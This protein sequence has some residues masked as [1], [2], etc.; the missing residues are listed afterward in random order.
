VSESAA[1]RLRS[2][3]FA[4]VDV[5]T[6]G[7]ESGEDR[8][9]EVAVVRADATGVVTHEWA[10]AVDPG[11]PVRLTWVHGLTDE[12][13]RGAPRFAEVAA[14]LAARLTGAVL[15]GHNV[16]FD[17]A[18]LRAEYERAG[19]PM[20]PFPALCTRLLGERLGREPQGWNL[21]ACCAEA[22]VA[23]G[24][25]HTALGDAR[26]AA[27]LLAAYLALA[28]ERGLNTLA[29]LGCHP[30]VAPPASWR[31]GMAFRRSQVRRW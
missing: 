31:T 15:V 14:A 29:G 16:A 27:A 20:P 17:L 10:T 13:L 23:A 22:G 24:H 2:R 8:V 19:T 11:G 25:A 3:A 1:G 21:A 9:V 26:S 28:G 18:F 12:L 30:L 5:E 4:V 7:L 6:T